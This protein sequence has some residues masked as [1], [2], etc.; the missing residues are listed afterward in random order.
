ME[1]NKMH[2]AARRDSSSSK[3]ILF[4]IPSKSVRFVAESRGL[5]VERITPQSRRTTCSIG[6]VTQRIYQKQARSGKHSL[7]QLD[8]ICKSNKRVAVRRM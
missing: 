4:S 3:T 7:S 8:S 1:I 6:G 2:G 5:I